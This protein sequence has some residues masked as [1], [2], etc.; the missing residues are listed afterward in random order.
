[1]TKNAE[2]NFSPEPTLR[3]IEDKIGSIENTMNKNFKVLFEAVT[4]NTG[5]I[6]AV[7]EKVN[8][9]QTDVAELKTDMGR[10]Q[11]HL[12]SIDERYERLEVMISGLDTRTK[13]DTD[14]LTFEIVK[15]K[16]HLRKK[17]E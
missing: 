14:A 8:H 5:Q 1:M 9:V 10:V 4:K 16:E 12:H 3:S 11:T 2:I 6:L 17:S 13:E 7:D 15:I